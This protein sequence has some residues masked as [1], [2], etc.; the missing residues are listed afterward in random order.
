M[1]EISTELTKFTEF[2]RKYLLAAVSPI[3]GETGLLVRNPVENRFPW[4]NSVHSVNSVK[5]LC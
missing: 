3:F 5:N 2:L 1:S 4:D